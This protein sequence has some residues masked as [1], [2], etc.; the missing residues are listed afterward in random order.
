MESFLESVTNFFGS[1]DNLPWTDA[2]AIE[3]C[4]RDVA[5]PGQ[6]AAQEENLSKLAWALVH[7]RREGDVL[8]GIA[9]LEDQL[10]RGLEKERRRETLYLTAVG[11]FR[12]Q[13]YLK[14]RRA[15]DEALRD[16]PQFYQASQLKKMVEQKITAD[17][18]IGVGIATAAVAAVGATV[19]I[20]MGASRR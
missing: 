15:V 16:S 17:G 7:S 14:S 9:M 5:D 1:S 4:E 8:R 12:T 20:V 3:A 11:Y 19:A 18:V 13:E 2:A 10:A 6:V